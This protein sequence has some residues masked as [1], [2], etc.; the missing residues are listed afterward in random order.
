LQAAGIDDASDEMAI[1]GEVDTIDMT[2]KICVKGSEDIADMFPR[3]FPHLEKL[4]D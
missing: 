4:K 3:Y 2:R 1:R